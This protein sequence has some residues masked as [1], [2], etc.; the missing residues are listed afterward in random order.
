MGHPALTFP[1]LTTAQIEHCVRTLLKQRPT[2]AFQKLHITS[3]HPCEIVHTRDVI[4]DVRGFQ[5]G[6]WD[7]DDDV[8]GVLILASTYNWPE[9]HS[10]CLLAD[11]ARRRLH[12]LDPLGQGIPVWLDKFLHRHLPGYGVLK[13]T[14]LPA[15]QQYQP[16]TCGV[17]AIAN[18][19]RLAHRQPPA[20]P[21]TPEESHAFLG[22]W[23]RFVAN[24]TAVT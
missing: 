1:G 19:A 16:A 3:V 23:L 5:V 12:Y 14:G 4:H 18:A 7:L 13:Y 11:Y 6:N 22:K 20:V 9:S 15:R 10:V 8:D 24:Q 21:A 17:W 2:A